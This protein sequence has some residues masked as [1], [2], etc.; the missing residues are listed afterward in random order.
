MIAVLCRFQPHNQLG[1]A[2]EASVLLA[3]AAKAVE[4]GFPGL[5]MIAR[6]G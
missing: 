6:T 5:P 3:R 2:E 4:T 1:R